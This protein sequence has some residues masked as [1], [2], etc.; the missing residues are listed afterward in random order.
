MKQ[1]IRLKWHDKTRELLIETA[2]TMKQIEA[3][4]GVPVRWLNRFL[5]DEFEHPS[6]NYVN[7]VYDFLLRRRK[8]C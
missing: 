2:C 1:K 3:G 4:T 7:A 5:H 8:K 6:V